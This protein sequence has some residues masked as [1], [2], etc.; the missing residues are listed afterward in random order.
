MSLNPTF[1]RVTGF[2]DPSRK[3]SG[4][5]VEVFKMLGE[6]LGFEPRLSFSQISKYIPQNNTF[7]G[8]KFEEVNC[9]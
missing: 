2:G 9:L 7:V 6:D 8:G 3:V 4:Y 5:G 1:P